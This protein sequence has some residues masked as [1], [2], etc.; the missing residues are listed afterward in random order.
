M[1]PQRRSLKAQT[2]RRSGLFILGPRSGAQTGNET[3]MKQTELPTQP[4]LVSRKQAAVMLGGVSEATVKR[5]EEAGILR[6][7]RLSRKATAQV[8]Y[9]YD[10]VV[11]AAKE[12]I[13]A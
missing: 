7:K 5:L 9:D 2:S 12:A 8:F 11:A 13:D 1:V 3:E 4:L 6:G 10:N